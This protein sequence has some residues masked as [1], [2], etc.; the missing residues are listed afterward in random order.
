MQREERVLYQ[1]TDFSFR[2]HAPQRHGPPRVSVAVIIDRLSEPA[3][4]PRF[5]DAH[6][7]RDFHPTQKSEQSDEQ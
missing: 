6:H 2:C 5:S 7:R 4:Q 3:S 1:L